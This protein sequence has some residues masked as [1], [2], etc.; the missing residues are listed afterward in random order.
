MI[1]NIY[2]THLHVR[3][4]EKAIDF[5]QNKLGLALARKLSKRKQKANAWTMGST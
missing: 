3:D 1:Q 5:Y 2:E 4:L